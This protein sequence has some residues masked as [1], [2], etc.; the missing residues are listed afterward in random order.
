MQLNI[1]S[2]FS[3][4]LCSFIFYLASFAS[5][6]SGSLYSS[7]GQSTGCGYCSR[8]SCLEVSRNELTTLS[9][10]DCCKAGVS[11]ISAG[12]TIDEFLGLMVS[13]T[14]CLRGALLGSGT[15]SSSCDL[16]SLSSSSMGRLA[17]DQSFC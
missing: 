9:R 5:S 8:D 7:G 1:F 3:S 13:K 12:F 10:L 2:C 16:D 4:S 17:E 11:Q 14:I 15:P 6:V